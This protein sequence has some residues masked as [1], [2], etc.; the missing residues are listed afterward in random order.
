MITVKI[1]RGAE[2]EDGEEVGGEGG[3]EHDRIT[4]SLAIKRGE[5]KGVK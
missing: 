1:L 4:Y 3:T 2:L 5:T